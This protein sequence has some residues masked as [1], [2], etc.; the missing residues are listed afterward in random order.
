MERYQIFILGIGSLVKEIF[1]SQRFTIKKKIHFS[2]MDNQ[3]NADKQ[4]M[5]L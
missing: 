4:N 5:G 1:S 2:K 3:T